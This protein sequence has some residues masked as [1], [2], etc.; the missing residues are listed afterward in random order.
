MGLLNI[1]PMASYSVLS[2]AAFIVMTVVTQL[3]SFLYEGYSSRRRIRKLKSQGIVRP[4]AHKAEF[5]QLTI[6]IS[7]LSRSRIP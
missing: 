7:S 5:S 6:P 1:A 4:Q 2:I 3:G